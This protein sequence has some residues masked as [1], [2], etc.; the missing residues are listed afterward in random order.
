MTPY[1]T[2]A[3]R[4]L[5]LMSLG[6]LANPGL[7]QTLSTLSLAQ[8]PHRFTYTAVVSVE[9]ASQAELVLR[10]RAWARQVT[11]A[12]LLPVSTREPDTEVIRTTGV[13]P[14]AVDWA[15]HNLLPRS[16]RY[17][18]TISV[19]E[20]RYKYEVKD[21]VFIEPGP[22][23]SSTEIPVESYYNGNVKPIREPAFRDLINM[24][25]CFKEIA[26][27]VLARLQQSMRK[28]SSETGRE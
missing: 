11:P 10:A 5:L 28:P 14:F 23:Q 9:G 15:G 13:C 27:E 24:R 19:R 6:S 21:F 16:L 22:G 26:D 20:G 3:F 25:T 4:V 8:A 1:S 2:V 7:G 12:T 18:A 17:N